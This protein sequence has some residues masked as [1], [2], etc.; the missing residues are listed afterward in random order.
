[1]TETSD[2]VKDSYLEVISLFLSHEPL[3][4]Y[5]IKIEAKSKA[6]QKTLALST[7]NPIEKS[8][9]TSFYLV[10]L[11][12]LLST[13][14]H[15]PR[16]LKISQRLFQFLDELSIDTNYV[17][18]LV[19][20]LFLPVIINRKFVSFETFE[21]AVI[22]IESL[23]KQKHGYVTDNELAMVLDS[24]LEAFTILI[25]SQETF[26]D[27][28]TEGTSTYAGLL[29]GTLPT[30][31]P[32]HIDAVL[33]HGDRLLAMIQK[34]LES[35]LRV[36]RQ[37]M[38]VHL[39]IALVNKLR[40]RKSKIPIHRLV[41]TFEDNPLSE[42]FAPLC[43]PKKYSM[44][45]LSKLY[46]KDDIIFTRSSIITSDRD[47]FFS[48][49]NFL[50]KL[51]K[52]ITSY[53]LSPK[54]HMDYFETSLVDAIYDLE[55]SE[56]LKY[57]VSSSID[58]LR[59]RDEGMEKIFKGIRKEKN[60]LR[61]VEKVL[62]CPE[63]SI[64]EKTRFFGHLLK[65]I[66]DQ[67]LN[68]D[69]VCSLSRVIDANRT[70]LQNLGNSNLVGLLDLILSCLSSDKK[71][72]VSN[73]IRMVA[74][75]L[76]SL[77]LDILEAISSKVL[78]YKKEPCIDFVMK[79]IIFFLKS[80]F[81]KYSRNATNGILWIANSF[82]IFDIK[83]PSAHEKPSQLIEKLS[84]YGRECLPLVVTNFVNSSSIKLRLISLNFIASEGIIDCLE[85]GHLLEIATSIQQLLT[86]KWVQ[87][88]EPD[89][90]DVKYLEALQ[91]QAADMIVRLTLKFDRL[92]IEDSEFYAPI[93]A[94]FDAAVNQLKAAVVDQGVTLEDID[95]ES[96][97]LVQKPY[98]TF[99]PTPRVKTVME[100]LGIARKSLQKFDDLCL[101]FLRYEKMNKLLEGKQTAEE[102]I[103]I[104]NVFVELRVT[105]D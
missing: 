90:S 99:K 40:D 49:Q 84:K 95:E 54:M 100:C 23:T 101:S 93:L 21:A 59:E 60:K 91:S 44:E 39:W 81:L 103:T 80:D 102:E 57:C 15:P 68:S 6:A 97:K 11:E 14:A 83:Q 25:Q 37:H 34:I 20:S 52:L 61:F 26:I 12:T 77:P 18:M 55:S 67:S 29:L 86:G 24:L 58:D 46:S 17:R 104:D 69:K 94:C 30:L 7:G 4:N 64:T 3:E 28:A 76:S 31:Y 13:D 8:L 35:D 38:I 5:V 85:T 62:V 50:V 27:A 98:L 56:F 19:E 42:S 47:Y 88:A 53:F 22:S 78:A 36:D 1:M 73:A 51:F 33:S 70:T 63:V 43:P 32:N 66:D 16:L 9:K 96:G 10:V 74:I 105:N 92:N 87:Q 41:N 2:V 72:I 75:L 71:K 45:V 89:F 48:F 79:K 82:K 65:L